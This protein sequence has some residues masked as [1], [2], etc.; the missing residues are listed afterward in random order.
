MNR[1]VLR[2]AT[3]V[4]KVFGRFV[5]LADFLD[6]LVVGVMFAEMSTHTTLTAVDV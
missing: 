5:S 1:L 4:N 6:L 2:M 3:I